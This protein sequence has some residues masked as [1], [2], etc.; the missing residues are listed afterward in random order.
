MLRSQ[1]VTNEDILST[2]KKPKLMRG[3]GQGV[4]LKDPLKK[5]TMQAVNL[6][7]QTLKKIFVAQ[8]PVRLFL[9]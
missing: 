8:N 4:S 1:G 2:F 6:A 3:R 7:F 5:V 9:N